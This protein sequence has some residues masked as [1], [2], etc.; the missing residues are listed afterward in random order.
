MGV[1][2]SKKE[3][4][5][6]RRA[7]S[8]SPLKPEP[9]EPEEPSQRTVSMPLGCMHR[10]DIGELAEESQHATIVETEEQK[11]APS[12]ACGSSTEVAHESRNKES[13]SEKRSPSTSSSSSSGSSSAS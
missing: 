11:S 8:D 9:E 4:N 13:G 12:R 2:F 10:S 7:P 1:R 6:A 3:E 5:A